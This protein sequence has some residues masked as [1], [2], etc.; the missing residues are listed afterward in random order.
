[1]HAIR[2]SLAVLA[3]TVPS[4]FIP[5]AA[6]PLISDLPDQ[7]VSVGTASTVSYFVIG[8]PD[9]SFADLSLT[10]SSS[11]QDLVSNA[12]LALAAQQGGGRSLVITPTANATGSATITVTVSAEGGGSS[13][14]S[15]QYTVTEPNAPPTLQGLPP[16]SIILLGD[17]PEPLSFFVGDSETDAAELAIEISSSNEAFVPSSNLTLSGSGTSRSLT[18]APLQGQPGATVI[19][20]KVSDTKGASTEQKFIF[21]VYDP[22]SPNASIAQPQGLHLLD[23]SAGSQVDGI[24]MRDRNMLD[25]SHIDGYVL[26]TSW[27]TLEPDEGQY[28]FTIIDNIFSVLPSWQNLSLIIGLGNHPS[29]LTELQEVQTYS[30]SSGTVLSPLPWDGAMQARFSAML[31]ALASHEIEGVPLAQHPRLTALNASIPGLKSGIRNPNG[32]QIKD[33]PGYSR[34]NMEQA[35]LT[36][37]QTV[38]RTFPNTPIQLGFWTYQDQQASP[39][40]WE[41]L[42]KAILLRHDG[43]QAPR[44]GFWMENLAANRPAYAGEPVTGLP[45]TSFSA[46][47]YNSQNEAWVGFQKLGS[48]SQ[49]FNAA[50]VDNNLN[51][52]PEDAFVYAFSTFQCRYFEIYAADANFEQYLDEYTRWRDFLQAISEIDTTET[53]LAEIRARIEVLSNQAKI[54]WNSVPGQTYSV[55]ATPDLRDWTTASTAIVAASAETSWEDSLSPRTFYRVAKGYQANDEEPEFE[56]TYSGNSFT[57]SDSE[58]S[59]SGIFVLPDGDGPFPAIVINHGTGGTANGFSLRRANEM[60]PWGA[61]CIG[62]S[63]THE[64]GAELAEDEIGFCPENL[65]R[66]KACIRILESREDIDSERLA[67]WGHSRGAFNAIGCAGVLG[68]KLAALGFSAGGIKEEDDPALSFPSETEA[69]GILAPTLMFHGESE[70]VVP[71]N[72]SALLETLLNERGIVNQRVL[73]PTNQHNLHQEA[74]LYADM[75]NRWQ[76]WLTSHNVLR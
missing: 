44:I 24:S 35:V 10:A 29:W 50:H 65:E 40:A 14:D 37:L 64:A 34:T 33:I 6:S 49:P 46:P 2:R 11:D 5:V 39:S 73:Y 36:H 67:L 28:D 15:F 72:A 53:K 42:R 19:R 74:E 48:W 23:S 57:Y 13:S 38:T 25:A 26:R 58:R 21:C 59:F 41:E 55:Q 8:N 30:T 32:I 56:V 31:E 63:L 45:I 18:L 16:F 47:L 43:A 9:T 4:F 17:E 66:V 7:V 62:P 61:A 3:T 60:S 12:G 20:I 75:L 52:T 76:A 51:G 70:S 1:M 69:S 22:S 54:S 68:D 71:P 27:D